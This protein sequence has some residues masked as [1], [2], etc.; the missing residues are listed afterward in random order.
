MRNRRKLGLLSL[1]MATMITM[2]NISPLVS[3][4]D[5]L[6]SGTEIVSTVSDTDV[7]GAEIETTEVEETT[8]TEDVG[9]AGEQQDVAPETGDASETG[10]AS[11]VIVTQEENTSQEG[12]SREQENVSQ[13]PDV[14]NGQTDKASQDIANDEDAGISLAAFDSAPPVLEG[15]EIL[16]KKESYSSNDELEL[17]VRAYDAES[18]IKTIHISFDGYLDGRTVHY[19]GANYDFRED[20]LNEKVDVK[21]KDYTFSILLDKCYSGLEYKISSIK[22]ADSVGNYKYFSST[23]YGNISLKVDDAISDKYSIESFDAILNEE[24]IKDKTIE[25]SQS[26]NILLKLKDSSNVESLQVVFSRDNGSISEANLWKDS[27]NN[28]KSSLWVNSYSDSGTKYQLHCVRAYLEDDTWANIDISSYKDFAFTVSKR[29]ETSE[30]SKKVVV[31]SLSYF[32]QDGKKLD[33]GAIVNVGSKIKAQIKTTGI[34]V[35]VNDGMDCQMHI[36]PYGNN[37]EGYK[38]INCTQDENDLNLFTADIEITDDMYPTVWTFN[39]FSVSGFQTTNNNR[40]SFIVQ[41][42]NGDVVIPTTGFSTDISYWVKDKDGS[43]DYESEYKYYQDVALY[44][45]LSELE[46]ELPEAVSPAEGVEFVKWEIYKYKYDSEASTSKLVYVGDFDDYVVTPYESSLYIK[47]AYNKKCYH[48]EYNYLDEDNDLAYAD[49]MYVSDSDAV[50]LEEIAEKYNKKYGENYPKEYGFKG[51]IARIIDEDEIYIEATFDNICVSSTYKY[52][53][54]DGTLKYTDMKKAF[55]TRTEFAAYKEKLMEQKPFVELKDAKF[56]EWSCSYE[57]ITDT[58]EFNYYLYLSAIYED[59]NVILVNYSIRGYGSFDKKV[60]F[61]NPTATKDE[62]SKLVQDNEPKTCSIEGIILDKWQ[63]NKDNIYNANYGYAYDYVTIKNTI[64]S[65]E[66]RDSDY[67]HYG[68]LVKVYKVGDKVSLPSEVA[69]EHDADDVLKNIKWASISYSLSDGTG[70]HDEEVPS[71]FIAKAGAY[72]IWGEGVAVKTGEPTPEPK[73]EPTPEPKPEPTPEPKP[74]PKPVIKLE[75][76]KITESVNKVT[77]A[78]EEAKKSE[79]GKPGG[80]ETTK[81]TP[82]V[83]I[84]MGDA[85]VVPT[86]ILEAAKGSDVDVVLKM[87]GY[88][89]T[90]N[91]K[92][93]KADTLK[94]IN[95]EVTMNS[96]AVPTSTVKKLAGDNP[97]KQLSLTH[98]GDFG[99][100]ATLN[101]EIGK[102]KAGQFGNLYWYDSNHQMKFMNAGLIAADGTVNLDFSHA[103]D[104]VIVIGENMTPATNPAVKPNTNSANTAVKTGDIPV[105]PYVI[106]MLLGATMLTT[107]ATKKRMS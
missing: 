17:K 40:T 99:F 10:N 73:P 92:D 9:E 77:S 43:I 15:V 36:S 6:V 41:K 59:K 13:I 8:Q 65:F 56:K 57:D 19:F 81:V 67:E 52:V 3:Y 23:D 75:E 103:S 106:L 94:D 76:E 5:E 16:N 29:S 2:T 39:W 78:I 85:T 7:V 22:L 70:D 91:G 11:D 86:A 97:T 105:L 51:Y 12:I 31:E 72:R 96:D 24:S 47:P 79:A 83:E 45:K 60:I 53:D 58:T 35:K 88:S 90:I 95:L 98:N 27:E 80:S 20:V 104:Y 54:T 32:D 93:I 18:K 71:E 30:E 46:I 62:I 66:V 26:P 1:A 28:F 68:T 100:K 48:V 63:V 102:D 25:S 74:D 84:P 33:D 89:W 21:D 49:D 50:N 61:V 82:K 64:V 37:I 55:M 69:C 101:V 14:Q 38:Y 87:D 42:E 107:V 4:A 34:D 44:S